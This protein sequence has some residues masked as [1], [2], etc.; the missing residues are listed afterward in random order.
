[1]FHIRFATN[2]DVIPTRYYEGLDKLGQA[3]AKALPNH[4]Q[5]R[6]EIAGHTDSVGSQA[7]NQILS[8]KR[9]AS[10]KRYLMD[11]F[12]ISSD[13][14]SVKGYGPD[15]PVASNNTPEGRERNRRVEAGRL[16]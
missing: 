3:L 16:R 9:A 15:S 14:L 10:V 1:V 6:I 11:R 4:P 12:P 13:N 5:A 2:S 7:Y 8:E